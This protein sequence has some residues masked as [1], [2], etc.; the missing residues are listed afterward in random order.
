MDVISSRMSLS[1]LI[2]VFLEYFSL[3]M[4]CFLQSV[5]FSVHLS[6]SLSFVLLAFLV[7]PAVPGCLSAHRVKAK[8]RMLE[9][10]LCCW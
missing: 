8:T 5:F 6:S 7:G 10:L 3:N 9:W 4:F 2:G 1:M